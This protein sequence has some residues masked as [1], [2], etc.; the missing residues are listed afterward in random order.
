MTMKRAA[1]DE[2]KKLSTVLMRDHHVPSLSAVDLCTP[3]PRCSFRVSV[4]MDANSLVH[5]GKPRRMT[6]R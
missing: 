2:P 3:T 1:I 4:Y 6:L 5:F